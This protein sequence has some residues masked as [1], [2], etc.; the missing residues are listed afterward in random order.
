MS[1]NLFEALKRRITCPDCGS[2][3]KTELYSTS[4]LV[5]TPTKYDEEGNIISNIPPSGYVF[6]R[7]TK[8]DREYKHEQ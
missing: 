7:C 5:H 3:A 4:Y 8:C 1:D 2:L 6:Y